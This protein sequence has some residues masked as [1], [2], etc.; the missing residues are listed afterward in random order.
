[1]ASATYTGDSPASKILRH[2]QRH[3]EASVRDLEVV[4]G[5]STTAVR[6]HLTNLQTRGMVDTTLRRNGPGRPKL[7][8]SLTAAAK[9]Q[10]PKA[11][12]TFVSMLLRELVLRNG[13]EQ[14]DVV[15]EAVGERLAEAYRDQISGEEL[16]ERL[17][18]LRVALEAR[19]I[20]VEIQPS[21][22]GF[23]VFACPYLDVAQEHAA[24]C[25]MERRMMETVLGEQL[26]LE[27]TIREG[28]RSCNFV[29]AKPSGDLGASA[30][31]KNQAGVRGAA[32]EKTS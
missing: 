20:P 31:G 3:G 6:E 17:D 22:E 2:L 10:F 14:L 1:M 24:V 19:S 18:G 5:V 12:D 15:L 30:P 16:Q 23:S 21:G 32:P 8:Y 4:L 27:G 7:V 9:S 29:V 28:K 13:P 26:H 25:R 11:Y